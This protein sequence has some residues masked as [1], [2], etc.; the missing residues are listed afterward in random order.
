MRRSL[1][2]YICLAILPILFVGCSDDSLDKHRVDGIVPTLIIHSVA[3]EDGFT[4]VLD[5]ELQSNGG[6]PLLDLGICFNEVEYGDPSLINTSTR[7][8]RQDVVSEGRFTIRQGL[9]PEKSFNI[10]LFALNSNGI[11]YS[12]IEVVS[13]PEMNLDQLLVGKFIVNGHQSY[14]FMEQGAYPSYEVDIKKGP[15][16]MG[17]PTYTIEGMKVRPGSSEKLFT[18]QFEVYSNES[19]GGVIYSAVFPQQ[20]TGV[21][22]NLEDVGLRNVMMINGRWL[23]DSD[24]FETDMYCE[25]DL[26]SGFDIVFPKGYAFVLSDPFTDELG[27]SSDDIVDLVLGTV[28]FP[29]DVDTQFRAE[30]IISK[31][32]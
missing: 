15:V 21:S 3:L 32:Y 9:Q 1:I 23:A 2:Q 13:T 6:Y 26:T 12:N 27:G 4:V 20:L 22:L 30:C 25:I 19:E 18:A 24:E 16:F 14:Y 29:E 17:I 5:A 8:I 7:T 28:T 31:K 10:R 11:A